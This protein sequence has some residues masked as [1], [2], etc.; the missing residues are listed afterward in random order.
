[1]ALKD[2]WQRTLLYFGLAEDPDAQAPAARATEDR[3]TER[4]EA[5][6][7]RLA[8]NTAAIEALRAEIMRLG[9]KL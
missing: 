3:L 4:L 2:T 8:D 1:M 5:M 6:E 7:R 9:A